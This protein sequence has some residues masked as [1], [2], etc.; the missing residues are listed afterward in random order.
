MMATA[1]HSRD[2]CGRVFTPL[3][4]PV[5]QKP[6]GAGN[7]SSGRPCIRA[8]QRGTAQVIETA[9]QHVEPLIAVAADEAT[10]RLRKNG[11]EAGPDSVT[12]LRQYAESMIESDRR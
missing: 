8:G 5:T 9:A 10:G 12:A 7:G 3:A 2:L 11:V 6:R 1:A 4:L